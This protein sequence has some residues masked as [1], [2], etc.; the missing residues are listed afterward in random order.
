MNTESSPQEREPELI[1]EEPRMDDLGAAGIAVAEMVEEAVESAES[2]PKPM[3][4]FS[5][6]SVPIDLHGM[7]AFSWGPFLREARLRSGWT[8]EALY[9]ETQIRPLFLDA[10]ET[11]NCAAL[12][13]AVYAL[14]YV[15]KLLLLYGVP[16]DRSDALTAEL[17]KCLEYEK[18]E[19]M[20]HFSIGREVN[21]ENV[22]K[23]R[24]I[25]FFGLSGL[26]C[27]LLL[28]GGIVF[29]VSRFLSGGDS[30]KSLSGATVTEE[31]L[32]DL[33]PAPKL[34]SGYIP[35]PRP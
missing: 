18:K 25:I 22:A 14:A 33:Q 7:D 9:K 26:V 5:M 4:V 12:P 29:G 6:P 17:R 11:E 16:Q 20:P 30:T 3:A 31:A 2:A 23:L 32:R 34:K 8:V 1:F 27:L 10:L 13:A 35:L 24:R 28:I 15:R 19:E 21:A